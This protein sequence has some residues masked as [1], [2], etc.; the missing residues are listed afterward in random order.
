MALTGPSTRANAGWYPDPSDAGRIR[1]WDGSSW[2]QHSLVAPAAQTS[3]WTGAPSPAAASTR[4]NRAWWQTW[5]AIFPGLVLCLPVGLVGLWL[6][7]GT[8]NTTK[9]IVT[10]CVAVLVVAVIASP[11]SKSDTDSTTP[12]SPSSPSP[13]APQSNPTSTQPAPRPRIQRASVPL[14]TGM[15]LGDARERLRVEHLKGGFIERRPSAA[16]PGTVLSQGLR[17]GKQVTWRS[18]VPLVVAVPLP[19][20]PAVSGQS[21]VGAVQ[22]LRSAGFRTRTIHKT[23]SSGAEGVVLSQSPTA[24]QRVRPHA[25]VTVVVAHVVRPV[26]STP[27]PSANCTPGYSPCLAPAYD[28]DCAGGSGDGPK[29]VYGTVRVTGSDPYGLDADGDGYGCD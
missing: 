14:L 21:G 16:Q 13:S 28:Y 24:G 17:S 22:I 23:V 26:V 15:T 2:T 12:A 4:K 8:S 18:S 5:W 19:S 29:Y 7:K 25:L 10:A 27:P 6:R 3:S 20:V 11:G 9:W 1:Y